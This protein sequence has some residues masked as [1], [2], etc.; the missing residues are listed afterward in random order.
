MYYG[1]SRERR[2]K[3]L[4]DQIKNIMKFWVYGEI[5]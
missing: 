1:I 4:E 5:F 2:V 3:L